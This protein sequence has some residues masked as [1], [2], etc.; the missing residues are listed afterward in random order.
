MPGTPLS[1]AI[2]DFVSW[3]IKAASEIPLTYGLLPIDGFRRWEVKR[4]IA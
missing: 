4:P 1:G 2:W 3:L